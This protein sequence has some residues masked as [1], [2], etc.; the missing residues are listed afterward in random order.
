[1]MRN[2]SIRLRLVIG[3]TLLLIIFNAALWG[4]YFVARTQIAGDIDERLRAVTRLIATDLPGELVSL[5]SR[6]GVGSLSYASL[7][8]R[9]QIVLR[10][11]GLNRLMVVDTS[12]TVVI[13]GARILTLGDD[14]HWLESTRDQF[15]AALTG[16]IESTIAYRGDDGNLYKSAFAPVRDAKGNVTAV[17]YAEVSA[18]FLG[19]L[20]GFRNVIIFLSVLSVAGLAALAALISLSVVGP[21]DRLV[22]VAEAIRQGHRP[23]VEVGGS[24][25]VRYLS[26]AMRRMSV[27][28]RDKERELDTL[29]HQEAKRA[30]KIQQLA[31]H[32]AHEVRNPLGSMRL[33]MDL[34]AA[35]ETDEEQRQE[36]AEKIIREIDRLNVI[37]T[38]FLQYSAPAKL[39]LSEFDLREIIDNAVSF[40]RKDG[41][42]IDDTIDASYRA[43]EPVHV[44]GDRDQLMQ[45]FLNLVLNAFE[46]S[47]DNV[48]IDVTVAGD[49]A[50]VNVQDYGAGI[51]DNDLPQV[52]EPF[53]TTKKSGT[54][55]GLALAK[56]VV[57]NHD[58]KIAIA[59][60]TGEGTTVTVELP[61][62]TANDNSGRRT[63]SL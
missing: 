17:L 31:A 54:G 12:G 14:A 55:L 20:D 35:D 32:V 57:Q 39:D 21:V 23:D 56:K 29:Y 40:A 2:L 8:K 51:S 37:T 62:T 28:I 9:M 44:V 18:A 43:M 63:E 60:K 48:R 5:L 38:Q 19:R 45:L 33:Y 13:D 3:A 26:D 53:F 11:F 59:S 46:A 61:L 47:S 27:S 16:D 4:F 24:R 15:R 6:S 41:R 36:Y 42:P 58:G 52:F 22:K 1:M 10:E 49:S 34:M 7:Q 30:N 50:L 25:E